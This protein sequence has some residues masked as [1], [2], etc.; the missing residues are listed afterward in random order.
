GRFRCG[1]RWHPAGLGAEVRQGRAHGGGAVPPDPPFHAHVENAERSI[2]WLAENVNK[3]G[4]TCD[5]GLGEGRA[6]FARL[7]VS[8]RIVIESFPPGLLREL[9]LDVALRDAIVVSITPYGQDG[10]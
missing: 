8:A 6:A 9:G 10:P 4:I 7:A 1:F 5:L 3:R 2:P